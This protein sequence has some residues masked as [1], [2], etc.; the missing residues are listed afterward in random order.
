MLLKVA[1]FTEIQET[2][3]K[4]FQL[5]D[6]DLNLHRKSLKGQVVSVDLKNFRN[7]ILC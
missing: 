4:F 1:E 5:T 6:D 2:E 7:Q 3:D